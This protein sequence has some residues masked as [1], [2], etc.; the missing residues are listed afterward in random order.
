MIRHTLGL[1]DVKFGDTWE[2]ERFQRNAMYDQVFPNLKGDMKVELG[3][4]ILVSDADE[5]PR[6]EVLNTLRSCVFPRKLTLETNFFYYGF[7]CLHQGGDWP[8][9]QATFYVGTNT[10]LPQELRNEGFDS[11]SV[12][13][14]DAG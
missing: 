3:D 14:K 4:I 6:N 5:I 7:Q 10:V 2:R 9:P 13:I 11:N 8:W 1:G 12:R